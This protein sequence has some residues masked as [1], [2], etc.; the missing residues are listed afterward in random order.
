MRDAINNNPVAQIGLVAVL[1]I[2]AGFLVMSS[3]GG[4]GEGA[5]EPAPTTAETGV[6]EPGVVEPGVAPT[7]AGA[8]ALPAE[9]SPKVPAPKLPPKVTAAFN[10]NR[11]VVLMIVKR[12]GVDDA[13]TT[14]SA[15]AGAAGMEGVSMFVVPV[16]EIARYTAITQGVEVS[17]V[18]ALVVVRPKNLDK[19]IPSASV[20]YGYQT[21]ES[22][23]Q[24]V[25]DA[26]YKGRTLDYH[27]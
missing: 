9:G 4:G 1:L 13:L 8:S 20:S 15:L 22:V 2:V 25:I 17:Q 16:D 26:R 3:M 12:G 27:P 11:T 10:A 5:E 21:P 7:A 18:P 24:A 14:A 23:R 6:V 19:G